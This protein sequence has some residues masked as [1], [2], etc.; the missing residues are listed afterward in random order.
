MS[1]A[2][3]RRTQDPLLAAFLIAQH[4]NEAAGGAVIAPWEVEELP[5]E[6]IDAARGLAVEL[7]E[8]RKGAA[9]VE[10]WKEKWRKE[11]RK[12]NG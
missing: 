9:K 7:P 12:R 5:E 6:W 10:D 2:R 1:L 11:H 8:L 3:T 4:V